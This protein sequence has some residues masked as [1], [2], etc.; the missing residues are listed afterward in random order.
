L[1]FFQHSTAPANIAEILCPLWFENEGNKMNGRIKSKACLIISIFLLGLTCSSA[2]GRT[3]Y[4][5]ADASGANDGSSWADAYNYL[6]DALADANSGDEIHVAEG[7]YTPDSNSSNPNGSGDRTATF[8][9]INGV[10]LKGGYAGFGEP[11]PNAWDVELYETILSGDLDGN[12]I[13]VN[14]PYDLL[15]EPS[16][17]ENSYHVVTGSGTGS[18]TVL[19][20]FTITGGNANEGDISPHAKGGGVYNYNGSPTISNCNIIGNVADGWLRSFGGGMYNTMLSHPTLTNCIFSENLARIAGGAI[21]NEEDSTPILT[22]CTFSRNSAF[23]A[24]GGICGS[25]ILTNCILSENSASYGGGICGSAILTNC[26][27]S[28]NSATEEGGGM[29]GAGTLINCTLS[30][31]SAGENGGGIYWPSPPMPLLFAAEPIEVTSSVMVES[32]I[33]NC[34]LRGNTPEQI[35]Y[36]LSRPVITYSNIQ[37]SW[38]GEGNIDADP[39]FFD[40]GY[41]DTNDVWVDGDY[42]LLPD[43]PCID[44]GDPNYLAEPNETDLDG[45]PR[46][47]NGRIDMGAYEYGPPIQ[48]DVRI[49]PRTISLASSGKWIGA[50]IWLPEGYNVADIEP[51]SIFLE[52]EIEPERFWLCEDNQTAIAKFDRGQVQNILG[53]GQIELTITG[54]LMDGTIFE[55]KDKIRVTD[56]AGSKSVK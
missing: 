16:R 40:P 19:D 1:G 23:Y 7:I 14:D 45:R 13:D 27:L 18:N 38:I 29:S 33:T 34:I 43:S 31:N 53:V 5:D 42:H 12:D 54:Q 10:T 15:N 11:E 52:N 2:A 4:V 6:Q 26:I 9:L 36:Y 30:G 21:L 37:G 25:A 49:V 20:G 39:L 55:G 3:I 32:D 51:N 8:Q 56:K 28:G 35:Y 17:A 44:A 24:G 22:N 41:W 46:V 50:F 48:A 47:I